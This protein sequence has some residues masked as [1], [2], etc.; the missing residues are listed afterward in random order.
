[1]IKIIVMV[2]KTLKLR[3]GANPKRRMH[4]YNSTTIPITGQR[5]NIKKIPRRNDKEPCSMKEKF[6]TQI[7]MFQ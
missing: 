6:K 5:T 1:M 4:P 7:P 3:V 2:I